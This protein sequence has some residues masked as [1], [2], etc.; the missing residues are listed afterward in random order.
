M[1]SATLAAAAQYL[2]D[3]ADGVG[4]LEIYLR[5]AERIAGRAMNA[6]RRLHQFADDVAAV[7]VLEDQVLLAGLPS[8]EAVP[9]CTSRPPSPVL[10]SS[11][12]C[13]STRSSKTPFCSSGNPIGASLVA[14]ARL[15]DIADVRFAVLDDV[16]DVV[17][18]EG[19][20]GEGE[21][22]Q[23]GNRHKAL[24]HIWLPFEERSA[25][26]VRPACNVIG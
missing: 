25:G 24:A 13:V 3:R 14:K 20:A 10:L 22:E 23:D 18:S 6:E 16:Q 21:A 15:Q 5:D 2:D 4:A 7:G 8:V 17:V 12:D 26:R 9:V 1:I 19:D 11:P